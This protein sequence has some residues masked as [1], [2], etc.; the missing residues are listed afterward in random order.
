MDLIK[1]RR[2]AA[3]NIA[4]NVGTNH[5]LSGFESYFLDLPI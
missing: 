5:N 2:G 4:A 1:G 3:V